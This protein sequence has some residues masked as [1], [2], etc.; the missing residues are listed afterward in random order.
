MTANFLTDD[1]WNPAHYAHWFLEALPAYDFVFTPRRANID[2]LRRSGCNAVE[3]LPFGYADD[4]HAPAQ[5]ALGDCDVFFAGG[6]DPDRV[7]WIS[8][9]TRAGLNVSLYGGY[10]RSFPQTKR[11]AKG[12]A[13]PEQLSQFVAGARIC[14][15]LVRA[16]NRDGHSMRTFELAAMRAC[17]L[18]ERTPEH[19]ELFGSEGQSVLYFSGEAELLH[20]IRLLLASPGERYRLAE[21]VH[22]RITAGKNKYSDR[23]AHMLETINMHPSGCCQA[24]TA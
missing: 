15:C 13:P 18:V 12:F 16:A 24:V 5:Q 23:L 8:A 1:P 3:Y 22:L 11:L 21:S 19:T 10:W 20:N 14:L 9:L 7:R 2:D 6:A 4:V 17:M